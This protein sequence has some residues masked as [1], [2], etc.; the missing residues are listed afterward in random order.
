MGIPLAWDD[1]KGPQSWMV[2][3]M[4]ALEEPHM[5][6]YDGSNW[7]IGEL[8]VRNLLETIER[9]WSALESET[10]KLAVVAAC[11][12]FGF[13]SFSG[14]AFCKSQVSRSLN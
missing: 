3:G 4:V 9:S 6:S 11:C 8:H 14:W 5:T 13:G 10:N 7:E 1:L 2:T 12:P